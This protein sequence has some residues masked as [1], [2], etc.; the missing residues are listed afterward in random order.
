MSRIITPDNLSPT[1]R[2]LEELA[3]FDKQRPTY[4]GKTF[5]TPD[6]PIHSKNG[7]LF[8]AGKHLSCK[9]SSVSPEEIYVTMIL[10]EKNR[11]NI[12]TNK[13]EAVILLPSHLKALAF[14]SHKSIQEYYGTNSV[15]E[16][17]LKEILH[18]NLMDTNSMK[19]MKVLLDALDSM[20]DKILSPD[21]VFEGTTAA[22]PLQID[23]EDMTPNRRFDEGL[24]LD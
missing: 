17:M 18:R 21:I 10:H 9:N 16:N 4:I 19:S 20:V 13:A 8:F 1:E 22:S 15:E 3:A 14:G 23:L 5:W 12:E 24:G 6:H 11:A 7:W 2:P